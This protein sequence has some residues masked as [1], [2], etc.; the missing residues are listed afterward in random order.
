MSVLRP[1]GSNYVG[2]INTLNDKFAYITSREKYQWKDTWILHSDEVVDVF[3]ADTVMS[4]KS[5]IMYLEALTAAIYH[6]GSKPVVKKQIVA[7]DDYLKLL[8]GEASAQ[9][10]N[11]KT[12]LK[13]P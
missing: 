13:C 11:F 5:K 3:K 8:R 7:Y 2:N 4:R 12:P 1:L 10:S 9:E 6:C